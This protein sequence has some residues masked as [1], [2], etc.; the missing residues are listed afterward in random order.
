MQDCNIFLKFGQLI[1]TLFFLLGEVGLMNETSQR[2]HTDLR[3]LNKQSL[4]DGLLNVYA[5]DVFWF[6]DEICPF[7]YDSALLLL[8]TQKIQSESGHA[9]NWS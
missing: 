2:G 7:I 5:I 8:T 4:V 9:R 1:S 6:L 3:F